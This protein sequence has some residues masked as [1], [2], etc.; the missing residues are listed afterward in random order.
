MSVSILIRILILRDIIAQTNHSLKFH[1]F[2]NEE[3]EAHRGLTTG[4]K[5]SQNQKKNP[6]HASDFPVPYLHSC[7]KCYLSAF[8]T[9]LSQ[10]HYLSN[11]PV[12]HMVPLSNINEILQN[13]S[14]FCFLIT[15]V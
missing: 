9:Q 8:K 12:I 15:G 4:S 7:Q 6:V 10:S 13:S 3:T 2:S 11:D 5:A 14:D 1:H